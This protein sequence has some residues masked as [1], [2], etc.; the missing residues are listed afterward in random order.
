MPETEP[1]AAPK[2]ASIEKHRRAKAST[3]LRE[4][5]DPVE[6]AIAA[7]QRGEFV[8]I[9]DDENRE[10]EGDLC[11]AA[12]FATPENIA[13]MLR[14]TSGVI[15]VPLTGERLDRLRIPMMVQQQPGD[16]RH[17]LHRLRRRARGSLHRHLGRRPRALP[18]TCSATRTPRRT[19]S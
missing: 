15:C 13:F 6:D 9:V 19:T 11:I 8:I 16:V 2:V 17:R 3:A 7:Y 4:Q 14:Y 1:K 12:E 10:N 5:M 18:S